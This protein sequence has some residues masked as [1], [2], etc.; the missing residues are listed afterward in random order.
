MHNNFIC[1][2]EEFSFFSG[3]NILFSFFLF[4]F[5]LAYHLQK[6]KI[7]HA[8]YHHGLLFILPCAIMGF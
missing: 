6:K 4:S 1:S 2:V 5:P 8:R 7:L 3:G